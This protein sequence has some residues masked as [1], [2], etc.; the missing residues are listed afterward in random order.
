MFFVFADSGDQAALWAAQGLRA[1][2]L[3]PVEV[4]TP[5]V[6]AS[7]PRWEHRV[8]Q[9]GVVTSIG[10]HRNRRLETGGVRGI[11]N[12]IGFLPIDLFQSGKPDDRQYAQQELTALLM[13]CFHG[14]DCPVMNRPVAQGM[15]G[16]WRHPAEWAVLA[17][18]AGLRAW[19]YRMQAGVPITGWSVAPANLPRKTVFVVGDRVSGEAPIHILEASRRLAALSRTAMLGVEFVD[20]PECEWIFAGASPQPDLRIG[21]EPL[22]DTICAVLKG[23]LQ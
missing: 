10:F 11:L 21:G 12:R 2:G 16:A 3:D 15:A 18:R 6:L 23:D 8:G 13:S 20:G 19:S 9:S 14:L 22:L 4:I 1:R 7:S 17:A 5:K